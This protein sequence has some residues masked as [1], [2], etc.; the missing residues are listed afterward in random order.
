M[1]QI[2]KTTFKL[3]R[4]SGETWSKNNP[5]LAYGE[6]GYQLDGNRL[7]IGDGITPWN[8]LEYLDS[9]LVKGY[10]NSENKNFYWDADFNEKINGAPNKIYLDLLVNQLYHYDD[11]FVAV[12][13]ASS[14]VASETIAGIA[15]LYNDS[16]SNEDGSMTQK[17]ITDE[18]N[19][20]VELTVKEE[21]ELIVFSL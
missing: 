14:I 1:T 11:V 5:I 16:G 17:A 12:G 10:Y 15:K 6:P 21:E 13:A 9:L 8:E 3:R 7:K 4:G 20:K 2:I 19:K 18:L